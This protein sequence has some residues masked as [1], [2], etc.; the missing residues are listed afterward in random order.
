MDYVVARE[1]IF[2]SAHCLDDRYKDTNKSVEIRHGLFTSCRLFAMIVM[3]AEQIALHKH[4]M[5]EKA[6]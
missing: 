3:F 1:K 5:G 6:L 4:S 2:L